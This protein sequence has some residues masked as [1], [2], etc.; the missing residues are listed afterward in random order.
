MMLNQSPGGTLQL[1]QQPPLPPDQ[2]WFL[3]DQMRKQIA[4]GQL[5]QT[6]QQMDPMRPGYLSEQL[7]RAQKTLN[8]MGVNLPGQGMFR[9]AMAPVREGARAVIDPVMS[10]VK[11][12]ALDPIREGAQSAFRAADRGVTGLF[13]GGAPSAPTSPPSGFHGAAPSLQ[14][15]APGVAGPAAA[16]QIPQGGAAAGAGAAAAQGATPGLLAQGAQLAGSVLGPAAGAYGLYQTVNQAGR[17]IQRAAK[18]I[19]ELA[20]KAQPHQWRKL[21]KAAADDV[22]KSAG[23]GA[24]SGGAV[25]SA[26]PIV[27][28][29]IGAIVGGLAGATSSFRRGGKEVGYG[30]MI[31]AT[32][33]RGGENWGRYM[34]TGGPFT[35]IPKLTLKALL[36]NDRD[37]AKPYERV[38][39][40]YRGVRG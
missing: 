34:A 31:D 15:A 30:N 19:P 37:E 5:G 27:G 14:G 33:P 9:E 23:E 20:P 25:G 2:Q 12:Y 1:G 39:R 32:I 26:I 17:G 38:Q 4:Q 36:G 35:H 24:I 8:Q 6:H 18:T 29:T 22:V 28:T 13:R 16:A 7:P 40:S 11:K 10:P 21:E 3:Q